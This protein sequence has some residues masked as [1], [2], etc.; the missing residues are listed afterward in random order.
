RLHAEMD[1][2]AIDARVD[3]QMNDVDVLRTEF[4]SHGLRDG[5]Q[6][7]FRGGETS[8]TC[9]PLHTRGSAREE[10]RSAPADSHIACRLPADQEP[11]IA[12]QFPSLEKELFRGIEQWLAY[13]RACV[14]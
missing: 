3:Q 11:R 7:E 14:E 6:S 2:F 1:G 4:A 10:H 12:G 13:V 5:A 9:R 8:E